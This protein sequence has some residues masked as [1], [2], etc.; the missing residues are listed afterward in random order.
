MEVSNVKL[1]NMEGISIF[2]STNEV[3]NI[4][5]NDMEVI[6]IIVS[7]TE[8]HSIKVSNM[9]VS[10]FFISRMRPVVSKSII[11]RSIVSLSVE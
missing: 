4:K 9:E 11:Y 6:S 2:V 7:K 8:I 3:N 1:N 5:V 10:S